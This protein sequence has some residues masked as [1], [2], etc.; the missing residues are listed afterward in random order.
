MSERS[1]A[2]EVQSLSLGAG[3]TFSGEGILAVAKAA[4]Q[5]GV[6][7]VGGYPGSPIS[8]LVDVFSE[9]T[10]VL[11]EYGV[12]FEVCASEAAAASLLGASINYPL[13]G[14]VPWTSVAGTT[15][16]AAPLARTTAAAARS[17]RA[18]STPAAT[19]QRGRTPVGSSCPAAEGA[20]CSTVGALPR[21]RSAAH[22]SEWGYC[23]PHAAGGAA[24][25]K[26]APFAATSLA[27]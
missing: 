1:F 21:G 10:E 24:T 14:L 20:I 17:A 3:D 19:R 16:A 12:H 18:R 23:V 9:A 7:Y 6:S 25:A 15:A 26:R 11:D 27:C 2:K 13:R 8:Q 4:L 5:S 22:Y